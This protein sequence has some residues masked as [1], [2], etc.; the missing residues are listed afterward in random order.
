MSSP[1]HSLNNKK[2]SYGK[3][4]MPF[5]SIDL[6]AERKMFE[7]M[8]VDDNKAH[9]KNNISESSKQSSDSDLIVI[10]MQR[11]SQL[12]KQVFNCSREICEKNKNIQVLEEKLELYKKY[13]NNELE[14]KSEEIM[15][16]EQECNSY[17]RQIFEMENFLAEHGMIWTGDNVKSLQYFNSSN[18]LHDGNNFSINFDNIISN[19]KRLNE[20]AGEGKHTIERTSDGA[21]LKLQESIPLTLYQNGIFL[22]NGPF[23]SYEEITTKSFL[24]DILDGYFPSELQSSY[25]D[26]VSIQLTDLRNTKYISPR[27]KLNFPGVGKVLGAQ[28]SSDSNQDSRDKLWRITQHES[29]FPN[30]NVENLSVSKT[31]VSTNQ[32]LNKLPKNTIKNGKVFDIRNSIV[33]HLRGDEIIN[34]VNKSENKST[35]ELKSGENLITI[36]VKTE[37]GDHFDLWMK[38]NETITDLRNKIDQNQPDI[39][40]NYDIITNFPR[41]KFDDVTKTLCE[42]GLISNCVVI[43]KTS[44]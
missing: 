12:E 19:I 43:L 8:V 44:I 25:P 39:G 34:N 9:K 18:Q 1:L 21:R 11:I 37:R 38:N 22:F 28:S 3:R 24:N 14:E 2:K 13:K 26:G 35:L 36:R 5:R 4:S 33:K 23:R 20:I 15:L 6:S 32:F 17:K 29:D 27:E 10:M 16:L 7:K 40:K 31:V 30:S 41:K 42:Y